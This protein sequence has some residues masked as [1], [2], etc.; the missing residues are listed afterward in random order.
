MKKLGL[1]LAMLLASTALSQ[2]NFIEI[3]VPL[4]G[5]AIATIASGGGNASASGALFGPF[6]IDA[7]GT[8]SPPLT[9]LSLLDGN[10]ISVASSG[11]P[12]IP[13]HVFVTE[14]GQTSP[15]GLQ[16]LE[17]SF[18]QNLLT[19]GWTVLAQTFADSTNSANGTQQLLNSQLVTVSDQTAAQSNT[20]NLGAGPFSLTEEWTI[21][22]P[23]AGQSNNTTDIAPTPSP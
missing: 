18:T 13:L 21:T 12:A 7:T 22:A 4:D 9:G 1:G 11:L 10:T 16:L 14:T 20:A 23:T 5:S 8:G 15:L 2:A 17:S 3:G 19:A 6:T